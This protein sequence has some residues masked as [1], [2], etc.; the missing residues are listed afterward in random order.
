MTEILYG[1]HPVRE[2]LA[3]RGHRF[4]E[5]W[6]SRSRRSR[7]LKDTISMAR[8]QGIKVRFCERQRLDARAGTAAHQ[9]ILAVLSPY[10]FASVENILEAALGEKPAL[11]LALDGVQDPQNLGALI[12]TAH[13]CGVH[14]VIL[15]KDRAAPLTAAVD[16]AS[17]GALEHTPV[18]RVTNLKRTLERLKKEGIWVVGLTPEGDRLIYELDL[19]QPTA[20]VI[21]GEASGIRPLIKKSCDLLAAIPQHGHLDSLNAAVAGTMA[22]YEAM[23][24][25]LTAVPQK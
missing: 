6:I 24:Q 11:I 23:R 12:R 17:A 16:K 9:G 20:L 14:G 10:S 3:T 13:L 1:I 21:G 25:R 19:C 4:Q 18:S 2:A 5:L 22:L 15:P 7:T 8:A